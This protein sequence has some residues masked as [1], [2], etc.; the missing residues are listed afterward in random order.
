MGRARVEDAYLLCGI[1]DHVCAVPLAHVSEAMRPLAVQPLAGIPPFVL[2]VA[3]IRGDPT[4]VVDVGQL[5]GVARGDPTRFVTMKVADRAV[6]IAVDSV[7][8]VRSLPAASLLTV[9]PL[10]G[11]ASMD[12][13]AAIGSLDREIL[14]VLQAAR[15]LPESIWMAIEEAGARA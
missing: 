4:P 3:I 14:L 15:L 8:G 12:L 10:L 5:V 11:V 7:L 13:V 6:A 9:P 2:G 1:G